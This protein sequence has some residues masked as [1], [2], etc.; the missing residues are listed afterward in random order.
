MGIE[1]VDTLCGKC[2]KA[3]LLTPIPEVPL[4]G[5][6]S[7][8]RPGMIKMV[9][10]ASSISSMGSVGS[11]GAQGVAGGKGGEQGARSGS[12]ASVCCR[13]SE[14]SEGSSRV[15]RV[16]SSSSTSSKEE[17]KEKCFPERVAGR[18][19]NLRWRSFGGVGVDVRFKGNG[20][21][22]P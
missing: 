18:P 21:F 1:T 5:P 19:V 10:S 12:D 2:R 3:T 16:G 13:E 14:E 15:E 6:G 17:N 4:L 9:S 22:G 11:M 20:F 8:E 7:E